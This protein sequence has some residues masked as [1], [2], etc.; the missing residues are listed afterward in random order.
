VRVPDGVDEQ[1]VRSRLRTVH[2]IE[3]TPG[4]GALARRGWVVGVMGAS[5]AREPQQRLVAALAS[6]LGHD[7]A[8]A[9]DAL[10]EG[11]RA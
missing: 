6:E 10:A 1:A 5:A 8:D 11:W 2:G 9:L 4:I 7:P 3:I